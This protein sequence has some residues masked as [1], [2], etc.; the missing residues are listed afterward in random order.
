MLL[1]QMGGHLERRSSRTQRA[2]VGHRAY[3][4]CFSLDGTPVRLGAFTA[5]FPADL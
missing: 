3:V 1:L 4:V 5:A 2:R